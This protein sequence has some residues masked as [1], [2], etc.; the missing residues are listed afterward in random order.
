MTASATFYGT[1]T[2]QI[3]ALE[4]FRHVVVPE[5]LARLQ[6]RV[7]APDHRGLARDRASA[8]RASA[9]SA[10][11]GSKQFQMNFGLDQRLQ[12]K[13]KR[14]D[15]VQ[16]IDNLLAWSM[17]GSYNFL[18]R[19]HGLAASA[20]AD[21]L[22]G[23][24]PAAAVLQRVDELHDR[25]LRGPAA[26]LAD[27]LPRA[28]PVEH[29]RARALAAPDLAGGAQ[30][31]TRSRRSATTGTRR[32]RIRTRAATRA[33]S[34]AR[35]A[36]TGRARATRT[37][38][39]SYQVSPAWSMEYSASYDITRAR[40]ARSAS[41]CRATSIAG[42]RRSRGRSRRAARLSIYFRLGVK[43]QREIYIERGTRAGS[44][45]GIN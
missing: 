32:S 42:R 11:P 16:R 12:V 33:G 41:R 23:H 22:G 31:R 43:E 44:I 9:A 14:K 2:P 20:A 28:Q 10:C 21:R 40:S 39:L 37:P 13:L 36:R 19:E 4:A 15:Q 38:C 8:S 26:A 30:R 45:G 35:P 34:S 25:R 29:R 1:F 5:R 18:W 24:A 6:P 27:V 7:P 17:G 3:G